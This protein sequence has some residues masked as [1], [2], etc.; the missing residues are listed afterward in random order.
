MIAT[1][2][3]GTHEIGGSCVE[4][5]SGRSRVVIDLGMPLMYPD[6]RKFD[7][8][9]YRGLT[10]PELL[11]KGILPAVDGL[12]AWQAPSVDGLLI[13]H[14]HQDHY[15]FLNHV[16]PRIPVH[17]GEGTKRLIEITTIF[18]PSK[19]HLGN[20]VVFSWPGEFT[21][22]AFHVVPHLVDHSSFGAFAFELEAGGKRLFYSGDFRDHG[23]LG[24]TLD[25]VEAKCAPGVDALLMEG[26]MFGREGDQVLTEQELSDKAR[27]ICEECS[28]AVLV[29]QSG[30]NVSR[31]VTFYK[32][33]MNSGREF[34]VDFYTAHVLADLAQ[35]R[36]GGRLPSPGSLPGIRV[37]FP[38]FLTNRMKREG[39]EDIIYRFARTPFKMSR[40][41]MPGRLD[42]IL[43]YVRPPM[44]Y[45]LTRIPGIEGS[46]LLYSLWSGYRVEG[47]TQ[48]FLGAIN[49]L[50][51]RE[52]YV[53][54]SGHATV[55]TMR[56]LVNI[57]KPK[58]LVPIHTLSPKQYDVFGVNVQRLN[59]GE[60]F[61]L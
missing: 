47:A 24:K 38:H 9:K 27:V 14:A 51:I 40:N 6:G 54:T 60:L 39:R 5:C 17:L 8:Q 36:G 29:Y 25:I 43:L 44:D 11:E 20:P 35:C 59:D 21:V 41:D 61:T 26:T 57:L 4:L 1:V 15:G 16:H 18:S 12:Y 23:Y 13:S 55:S 58:A 28:K 45:D 34:V 10:G 48:R 31:A 56:R 46:V 2:H 30:Q 50:G 42:K 52:Q 32:A 33:A 37:W 53:H 3:R 22:G 49:G 7:F 19:T